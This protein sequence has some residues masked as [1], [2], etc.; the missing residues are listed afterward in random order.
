MARLVKDNLP[1]RFTSVPARHVAAAVVGNALEFYDFLTYA[2]FAVYI[3]RVFFPSS[4]PSASLLA[5][6]A[7][8]G[9]GFVT[10]PIGGIVIGRMGDRLGRRP[11]MLL[12]FSL[13]GIAIVGLALTPPYSKIR[14]AAPILVIL[15]RLLQGFA[16][17][18]EVGP[19][20]AFMLEAASPGRRGFYA[21]FQ[22]WTQGLSILIS[23]L[24]GFG[25]AS[26]LNERQLQA[27]GWRIAFLLGAVI[28]PFGMMIRRSLPETL[29]GH[30]AARSERV[31]WR[32]Y[33]PVAVLGFFLLASGTTGSYVRT[34]MTTYA[35]LTL[36]MSAKLGFAAT[37]MVGAGEV[38]ACLPV[39]MLSDRIGRKPV[40]LMAGTL[41]SLSILPGF[42][43]MENY[44]SASTLL[45]CVATLSILGAAWTTPLITWLAE[46]LPAQIRA[47]GLA[48]VYAAAISVFG[49]TTQYVVTWMI[50]LTG[51]PLAPGYYWT[52]AAVIGLTAAVLAHESSPRR[53]AECATPA[54]ELPDETAH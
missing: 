45:A 8:F 11:A 37:I 34:Y 26:I 35:I 23:G 30:E 32:P 42:R 40:M 47:S 39:G 16:L 18:G 53:I 2:Y 54:A 25:I 9:A 43:I 21:A 48:F 7:T 49:G 29:Y 10:R 38:L 13:M 19:T 41:L 46:S 1:E 31:A 12:S 52:A 6:L 15:F 50:K 22:P 17:G 24:V 28:V 3:G 20:T 44:R 36:N 14:I 4:S 27:F 51:S 5:S 33:V